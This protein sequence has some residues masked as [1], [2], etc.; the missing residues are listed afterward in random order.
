MQTQFGVGAA[1][2]ALNPTL[3]VYEAAAGAKSAGLAASVSYEVSRDWTA[4]LFGGYD[5]LVG[6]AAASPITRRLD[7]TN[8]ITVG[9][10]FE[11]AF[12]FP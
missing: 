7:G 5:R 1:T 2:A 9:L 8:Q 10:G 12:Q 4:T 3:P 6:S 11:R